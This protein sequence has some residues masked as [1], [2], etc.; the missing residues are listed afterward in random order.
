MKTIYKTFVNGDQDWQPLKRQGEIAGTLGESRAATGLVLSIDWEG[1]EPIGLGVAYDAHFADHG[2]IGTVANGTELTAAGKEM[3]AVRISLFGPESGNYDIV[4][5]SHVQDY[6]WLNWAR[7]GE[8]SGTEGLNKRLEALQVYVAP[9]GQLFFDVNTVEKSFAPQPVTEV[10]QAPG[11]SVDSMRR[12]VCDIAL[13]YV[14]Y[15]AG[16]NNYS[17]FGER[18]G[19]PNGEWCAFFVKSVFDD[20]GLGGLV[21]ATGWVPDAKD[22]FIAHPTAYFYRRGQYTPKPG[23]VI[24]FDYNKNGTPDHT[25]IVIGCDGR[26]ITTVEGNTGTPRAVRHKVAYYGV[27]EETVYGFG[28]PDYEGVK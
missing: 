6:G 20:A 17:V 5:R 16:R 13:S 18:Y 8:T 3:Q 27:N 9:K 21:V 26:S 22:W 11:E 1:Q 2:W 10:P 14:G 25:G 4:Y 19:A 7:N 24:Y 12:R 15:T 23:D 28:V